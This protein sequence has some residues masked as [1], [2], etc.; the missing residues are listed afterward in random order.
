M[1]TIV[2][3]FFLIILALIF[4]LESTASQPNLLWIY[5]DDQSPWYSS[6]GDE[7][8][9]TPNIDELARQGVLFERAYACLSLLVPAASRPSGYHWDPGAPSRAMCS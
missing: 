7:L 9:E 8:V 3:S 1:H 2:K 6:Y 5:V 4:G